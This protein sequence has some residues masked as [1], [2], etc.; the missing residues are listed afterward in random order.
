MRIITLLTDFGLKDGYPGVMK[1]VIYGIA[2]EVNIAD[3]TH[4][5]AAQNIHEGALALSRSY[6]YFP[7]GTIHVA[8]VDPGVGTARRPIAAQVGSHIFVG[9]DNGLFTYVLSEAAQKNWLVRIY[10][11]NKQ[12]YW[13]PGISHVFHGRDVFAPVAAHLA[14]GIL[15]DEI[16]ER[17]YDPVVFR[18]PAPIRTA[19][20]WQGEITSVDH[21][22]N[23]SSNILEN[24]L[25]ELKN[26]KV[27][28]GGYS[29]PEIVSTFG[30]RAPGSLIALIGTDH[31]LSV[32]IVNGDAMHSLK[33]DLGAI[34][35]VIGERNP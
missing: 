33:L 5:I 26:P 14:S 1:G 18:V 32:A 6:H 23:L 30:D 13:L 35:E 34:I 28:I 24:H 29:I 2:P 22:G 10:H 15:I 31:D 11:L 4:I 27:K 20:G 3:I 7:D 9:P 25:S 8:V 12:E 17:V 21:F 19:Y 16:G